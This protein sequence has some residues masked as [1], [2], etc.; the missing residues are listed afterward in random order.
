MNPADPAEGLEFRRSYKQGEGSEQTRP[1]KEADTTTRPPTTAIPPTISA[2]AP[3]AKPLDVRG[4]F[5]RIRARVRS[6][7]S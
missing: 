1:L 4:V 5:A 2:Q 6:W 7:L 3:V